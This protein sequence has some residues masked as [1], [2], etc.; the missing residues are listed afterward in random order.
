MLLQGIRE[1]QVDIESSRMIGDSPR[2][3]EAAEKVG[4]RGFLF[5][6]SNLYNFVRKLIT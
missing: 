5:N 3:I 2:D 1:W 4:I 6:E